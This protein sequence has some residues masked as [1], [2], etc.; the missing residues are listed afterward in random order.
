MITSFGIEILVLI[1]D[2]DEH[3]W[4]SVRRLPVTH[5]ECVVRLRFVSLGAQVL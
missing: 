5:I 2:L 1:G 4:L 3:R